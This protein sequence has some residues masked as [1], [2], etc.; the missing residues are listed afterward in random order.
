[1]SLPVRDRG[2]SVL[3]IPVPRWLTETGTE[4]DVV[5]STRYR[6]ARNLS[7]YP[8]PGRASEKDRKRVAAI[9]MDAMSRTKGCW[10]RQGALRVFEKERLTEATLLQ[11]LE[12]RYA[13]REWY[14]SAVMEQNAHRW[15][16]IAPDN[17]VSLLVNEED[18][19]RMQAIL[20][21][22]QVESVHWQL[23][24]L[25]R[26][27]SEVVPFA[28]SP[29]IGFLTAS[30]GNAGTALRVSVLLHLPGLAALGK[31]SETLDAAWNVG[32]S[33]RGLY[34]EG[35]AGTGEL[36]QISNA[37]SWGVTPLQIITRVESAV[38][39]LIAAERSARRSGFGSVQ[40]KQSLM[41]SVSEA[42]RQIFRED[43]I[44][45]RLLPLVSVL[46]LAISEG[47]LAGDLAKANQ[48]I[49][50]AGVVAD[51]T[52]IQRDNER[53]EAIRRTA[54]LRQELRLLLDGKAG[55]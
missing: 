21:G 23:A 20:P 22:L 27:L 45:R 2:R 28:S 9:L 55:A 26:A 52:A 31:R 4:A 6:L 12:W 40:G 24:E 11:L 41:A 5:L 15:L 37:A 54:A 25:E 33:V 29:D 14:R 48:W 44:P 18:H 1:M 17:D 10:A 42:I 19:L 13:S 51:S 30:L 32:C 53:Y 3:P 46:R 36:F 16:V 49:A 43:A 39:Y 47:I 7:A 38:H 8:F 34:G 35:T 50:L